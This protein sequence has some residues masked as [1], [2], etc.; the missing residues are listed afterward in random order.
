M[1]FTYKDITYTAAPDSNVP[2]GIGGVMPLREHLGMTDE[3][4]SAAMLDHNTEITRQT[5]A[6]SYPSIGDQLDALFHAGA[7]PTEMAT[8]I[9]KVKEANPK[10]DAELTSQE[11]TP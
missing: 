4:F 9:Q 1:G 3:A 11:A 6:S 5:R 2:D 8:L 10:P 7:F